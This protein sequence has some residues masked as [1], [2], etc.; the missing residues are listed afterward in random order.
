MKVLFVSS[1]CSPIVKVG[2]LGDV[3]GSLPPELN[4]LGVDISIV[5]PFYKIIHLKNKKLVSRNIKVLFGKKEESFSLWK[6]TLPQTKV[7]VYLIKNE[8]YISFGGVYI[9]E[10]ASSGGTKREA[11]RFLF[12]SKAAIAVGKLLNVDI[13]HCN[14][15]QTAIIPFLLKR[16]ENNTKVKTILTIHNL[17]YQ[18]A[19]STRIVN[20]LLGTDFSEGDNCLKIGI[21]NSDI[22]T[23]VSPTYAKEILTKEFSF[24][25]GS[26][27]KKRKKDL[28]GILNG[29]DEKVW[30]SETDK[31]I[32]SNYSYKNIKEKDK[33]KSYLQKLF[34][35]KI[36]PSIPMIAIV[37]RLAKQKGINLIMDIFSELMKKNIQFVVLGKGSK[38]YENFFI[39]MNKKYPDKF[40]A[41]IDFNE[42]L[43]H[44]IYAGSDIFLI[45][46]FYE[47]CG[48]GQEISMKYGTV[49]VARA[50][51]GLKDTVFPVKIFSEGNVKGTG[52][53]FRK[54]DSK[55]L[56]RVINKTLHLYENKKIWRK[57]QIN[58]MKINF[59]W[60]KSA[61]KYK[62]LY[63][64]K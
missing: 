48:L 9:E 54:F 18:G 23:T 57:I 41:N 19:Y 22:I 15:W 58:G 62:K 42:K 13:F 24:G 21:L 14:D 33:N 63:F 61:K 56:L 60:K 7:S 4:N 29:L 3:A 59:S 53:T 55:N 40:K 47:P 45:P 35:A 25:L 51:G 1:E 49:P 16:E 6:T 36:D 28:Y 11:E 38:N 12:F 8:K 43:A 34:F 27:L 50:V 39:K 31:F 32:K 52:F 64:K 26:S 46:S 10:D 2:G 30:N 17:G 37:S 44:Q 5:I 20:K